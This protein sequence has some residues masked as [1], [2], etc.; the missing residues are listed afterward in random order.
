MMPTRTQYCFFTHIFQEFDWTWQC[1]GIKLHMNRLKRKPQQLNSRNTALPLKIIVE[2]I[3]CLFLADGRVKLWFQSFTDSSKKCGGN[4]KCHLLHTR[5]LNR[6]S[7]SCFISNLTPVSWESKPH[8]LYPLHPILTPHPPPP[9]RRKN[10]RE[11]QKLQAAKCWR[12][13]C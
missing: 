4:K 11:I 12:I 7:L 8:P 5:C 9:P 6:F 3:S 1:E 2:V 10:C 13:P